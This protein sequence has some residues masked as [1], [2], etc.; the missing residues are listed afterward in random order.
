[1]RWVFAW[2]EFNKEM[3]VRFA[4]R[5]KEGKGTKNDD[6]TE[7]ALRNGWRIKLKDKPIWPII[8]LLELL[9]KALFI[10]TN[11]SMLLSPM[12]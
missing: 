11:Q 10:I 9:I 8:W 2:T 12:P 4:I 3:L 5:D 7:D 6:P 1:M